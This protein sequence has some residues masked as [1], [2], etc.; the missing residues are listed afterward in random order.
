MNKATN[1]VKP[2]L[3]I[4]REYAVIDLFAQIINANPDVKVIYVQTSHMEDDGVD[5]KFQLVMDIDDIFDFFLKISIIT[6]IVILR[7]NK[8][9]TEFIR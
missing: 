8:N 6:Q 5:I 1:S 9:I 4:D 7:S 3:E 2:R